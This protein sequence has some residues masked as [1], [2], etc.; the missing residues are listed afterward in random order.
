MGRIAMIEKLMYESELALFERI[1][2]QQ[3]RSIDDHVGLLGAIYTSKLYALQWIAEE[4]LGTECTQELLSPYA[5][6]V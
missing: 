5:D 3:S 6:K 2:A 1:Y 4:E